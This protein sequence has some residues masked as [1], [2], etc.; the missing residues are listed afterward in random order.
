MHV[1]WGV[2][3]RDG[4]MTIQGTLHRSAVPQTATREAG[5]SKERVERQAPGAQRRAL[6]TML[7][8]RAAPMQQA[9]YNR[10]RP[11]VGC[12]LHV[13]R[14]AGSS[15][16]KRRRL[17]PSPHAPNTASI[18]AMA[19]ECKMQHLARV[20]RKKGSAQQHDKRPRVHSGSEHEKK[21]R[22]LTSPD[23]AIPHA[24]A[25]LCLSEARAP[26]A[27][28]TSSRAGRYV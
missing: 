20:Q 15:K 25:G 27:P 21:A 7:T 11:T 17:S 13:T 3:G 28:R 19:P 10:Q 5:E 24:G 4:S 2:T 23:I 26:V 14:Q 9:M 6:T 16:C 8:P 12:G 1:G 18:Y 22:T